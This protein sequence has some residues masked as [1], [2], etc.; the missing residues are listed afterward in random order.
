M[1]WRESRL[2]DRQIPNPLAWAAGFIWSMNTFSNFKWSL[3]FY[4]YIYVGDCGW[5]CACVCVLSEVALVSLA[6]S[7]T[8]RIAS[9]YFLYIVY[10]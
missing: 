8:L 6:E 5:L 9:V 10:E 4:I 7:A 3:D 1:R 2:L